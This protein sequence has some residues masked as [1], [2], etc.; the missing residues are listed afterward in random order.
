M[1]LAKNCEL[2][3]DSVRNDGLTTPSW[4]LSHCCLNS[5]KGITSLIRRIPAFKSMYWLVS[6]RRLLFPASKTWLLTGEAHIHR[7]LSA[8]YCPMNEW[9]SGKSLQNITEGLKGASISR[10]P[11]CIILVCQNILCMLWSINLLWRDYDVKPKQWIKLN[12]PNKGSQR[13]ET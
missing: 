3:Y 8:D 9:N 7:H 6:N 5:D 10:S 13:L 1:V 2:R 12:M 4:V 11:S